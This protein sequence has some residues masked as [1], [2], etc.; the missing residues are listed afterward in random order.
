MLLVAFG[1][2]FQLPVV[3]YFLGKLGIIST[4]LLRK[5]RRYAAVAILILSA[6]LTPADVFTQILLAVP[7]Y[8]LYEIAIIVVRLTGTRSD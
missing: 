1:M 2:S 7:L 8:I 4:G 6:L 3:A 5:G